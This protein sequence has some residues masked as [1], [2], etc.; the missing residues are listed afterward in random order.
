MITPEDIKKKVFA[1]EFHGYSSKQV[2]VFLDEI[3]E[4]Y[5]KMLKDNARL[6]EEV[7]SGKT[8]LE[9][10]KQME[11]Y[12]KD[13][14][15]QAQKTAEMIKNEAEQ[16]AAALKTE[17]ETAAENVKSEALKEA[18]SLKI[19]AEKEAAQIKESVS[20]LIQEAEAKA[21]QITEEAEVKAQQITE[22]AEA[23]ARQ[24]TEEAEKKEVDVRRESDDLLSTSREKA[25]SFIA[26]AQE[27]AQSF[28]DNAQSRVAEAKQDLQRINSESGVIYE[29][30]R[31][32]IS[33]EL[34]AM[35]KLL[36]KNNDAVEELDIEKFNAAKEESAGTENESNIPEDNGM[37][38]SDR[39]AYGE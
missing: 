8:E 38:E 15:V 39:I 35:K 33:S 20:S 23:K 1:S 7:E 3:I 18:E 2:D 32:V 31:D 10:L 27:R 36:V 21:R 22:E 34:T 30:L 37:S 13:A 29:K 25:E 26:E 9:N 14:L 16:K 28:W 4:D 24:I 17:T 19:E 12:I 5:S 11:S 6:Q